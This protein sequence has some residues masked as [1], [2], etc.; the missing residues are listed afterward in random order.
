MALQN[1]IANIQQHA[2]E[3][4]VRAESAL[5]GTKPGDELEA[6]KAKQI[7]TSSTDHTKALYQMARS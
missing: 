5:R 3:G 7:K 2:V 6:A 1:A 4:V